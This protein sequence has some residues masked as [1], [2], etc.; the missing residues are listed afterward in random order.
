MTDD[1]RRKRPTGI[2]SR[3]TAF[4]RSVVRPLLRPFVSASPGRTFASSS[5]S[6]SEPVRSVPIDRPSVLGVGR[7][8]TRFAC[9]DD[10]GD[11]RRTY[12]RSTDRRTDGPTDPRTR[13][14]ERA[15]RRIESN[16]NHTTHH[17]K[18]PQ[19]RLCVCVPS[20]HSVSSR[21]RQRKRK[22]ET[23]RV[24]DRDRTYLRGNRAADGL[25]RRRRALG[26]RDEAG[27]QSEGNHDYL[28]SCVDRSA[29]RLGATDGGASSFRFVSV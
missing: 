28:R 24:I 23:P 26:E 9:A 7:L 1:G 20:I 13:K 14:R 25:L 5:A 3:C 12:V 10:A 22:E 6:R 2:A 27:V 19:H 29:G 18:E 8:A 17:R 15:S 4:R 11:A 16:R 21:V